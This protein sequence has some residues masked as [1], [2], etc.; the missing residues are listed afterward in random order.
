[1][2]TF[3]QYLLTFRQSNKDNEIAMLAEHVF[4]DH[5]FPKRSKNYHELSSYLEMNTDYMLNMTLFDE[6]WLMYEDYRYKRG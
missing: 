3:Y 2:Q 6:V 4:L 5:S 1:M